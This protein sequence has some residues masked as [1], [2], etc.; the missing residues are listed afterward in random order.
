MTALKVDGS[1]ATQPV[2]GTVTANAGTN[3]NTSALALETGGNLAALA[4]GVS[5]S[6]Y[7]SNLKQVNGVTTQTRTGAAG[8]GTQRVAVASD[9]SIVLAAGVAEV[10]NVKNSGTFAVQAAQSGTWTV[11]PGNTANTTA[12]KVDASD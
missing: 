12:W 2:T 3:L 6:V 10:G 5:S 9:S 11:Q 8:T 4:G 7:Q 1:A